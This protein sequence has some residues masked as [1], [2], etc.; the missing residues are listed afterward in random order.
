MFGDGWCLLRRLNPMHLFAPVLSQEPDVQWL[1]FVDVVYKCFS[2]LYRLDRCELDGDL[3]HWLSYYIFIHLIIPKR[4][5]LM[6]SGILTTCQDMLIK[7][8]IFRFSI[9]PII[10]ANH[11]KNNRHYRTTTSIN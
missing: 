7:F 2:F 3:F 6:L 9:S 10:S 1:S 4:S 8:A 11:P 5:R